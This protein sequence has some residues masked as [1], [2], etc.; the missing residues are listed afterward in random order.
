MGDDADQLCCLTKFT[1]SSPVQRLWIFLRSA[2]ER[3]SLY[4]NRPRGE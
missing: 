1:Y 2:V 3:D 4:M